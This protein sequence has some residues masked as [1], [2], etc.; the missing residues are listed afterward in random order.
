MDHNAQ[1]R[2]SK[3]CYGAA[4]Y[5]MIDLIDMGH[6]LDGIYKWIAH[7]IDHWSEYHIHFPMV[8]KVLW[9]LHM[10]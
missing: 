10:T 4:S 3:L 9:R 2:H 7:Y 5:A 6:Q 8:H 1:Q